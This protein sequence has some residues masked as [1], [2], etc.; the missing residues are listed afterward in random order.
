MMGDISF[1]NKAASICSFFELLIPYFNDLT[2][3]KKKG[4]LISFANVFILFP[5]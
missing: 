4:V 1:T 2:L 3:F 5:F